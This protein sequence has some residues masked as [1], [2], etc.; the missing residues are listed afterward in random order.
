VGR[1]TSRPQSSSTEV[2]PTIAT[3]TM[4]SPTTR[5]RRPR[6]RRQVAR[7]ASSY[8]ASEKDDARRRERVCARRG[9]LDRPA[10]GRTNHLAVSNPDK[11]GGPA[12]PPTTGT[13]A[14]PTRAQAHRLEEGAR[15]PRDRDRGRSGGVRC[16]RGALV[17]RPAAGGR[18][19]F[20]GRASA[21][22]VVRA[23]SRP[24]SRPVPRRGAVPVRAGGQQPRD[25]LLAHERLPRAPRDSL[26]AERAT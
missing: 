13:P 21:N 18:G 3:S 2:I 10:L 25:R 16:C 24:V 9:Q 17:A 14:G 20:V 1:R 26:E 23:A 12:I 15:G 19:R 6:A 5:T 22:P 4:A 11:A 7:V 8:E